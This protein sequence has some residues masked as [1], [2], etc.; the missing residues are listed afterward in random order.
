MGRTRLAILVGLL[1]ASACNPEPVRA[2]DPSAWPFADPPN[3][4]TITTDK[5]INAT[6]WIQTVT[7][8]ADDGS[9]QFLP[10][11]GAPDETHARV[12]G[13]ATIVEKDPT[14]RQLATLPLGWRAWREKPGSSWK[15][16]PKPRK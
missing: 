15:R 8:D 4:A 1:V 12:V 10:P 6:A 14:V 2:D 13:L 16:E 11:D 3:V 9:W 7:H 5:I